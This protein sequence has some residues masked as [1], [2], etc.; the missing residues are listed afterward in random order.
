MK[1]LLGIATGIDALLAFFARIGG[2]FGAVLVLVVCYDVITRYFGV[3]KPFGL[4]STMIQESEYWLHSYLIV[5]V[6]GYA[7]VRNAH[8]RIDL[9]RDL[10]STRV[11]CWIEAIGIVL[12]LVPYSILGLWLAWPYMMQSFQQGEISKSQNGLSHIWLLK[13][14]LM[15]LFLLLFL[16]AVSQLIKAISG[17]IGTPPDG[18]AGISDGEDA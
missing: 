7:Y 14:G 2:W 12:L 17:I 10:T 11:K 3:P 9:V 18:F 16:A 5:L 6:V 13:G 15:V 4:N 1:R 8:V